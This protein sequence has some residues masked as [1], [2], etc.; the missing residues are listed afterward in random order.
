MVS[1]T[2]DITKDTRENDWN[3]SKGWRLLGSNLSILV[4]W[5]PVVKGGDNIRGTWV[6]S[7]GLSEQLLCTSEMIPKEK[8]Y[9]RR[10][11]VGLRGLLFPLPP[12]CSLN[13]NQK[14][15]LQ[16]GEEFVPLR[17]PYLSK[18][19]E[20]WHVTGRQFTV[21]QCDQGQEAQR[22]IWSLVLVCML[23]CLGV[24]WTSVCK[25]L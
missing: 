24:M 16:S 14:K 21:F 5:F 18:C 9:L 3:L 6:R 10:K 7:R 11:P 13:R 2:L 12:A 22:N 4:S 23:K 1:G 15:S 25:L 19:I 8:G 20:W 17:R